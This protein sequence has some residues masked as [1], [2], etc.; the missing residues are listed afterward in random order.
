MTELIARQVARSYLD[1]QVAEAMVA[2]IGFSDLPEDKIDY[3]RDQSAYQGT[4]LKILD[5]LVEKN[6]FTEQDRICMKLLSL[7]DMPGVEAALFKSLAELDTLDIVNELEVSGWVKTENQHFYLHPMMQ[8]YI[9]TW[10]WSE[11]MKTAADPQQ[12]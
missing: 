11:D 12:L 8:E 6:R 4:L 3:V 1:L 2:G 5:R 7:F 9:R 10:P